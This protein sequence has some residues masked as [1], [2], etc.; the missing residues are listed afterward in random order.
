MTNCEPIIHSNVTSAEINNFVYSLLV[1]YL[2]QTQFVIRDRAKILYIEFLRGFVQKFVG[3]KRTKITF[4]YDTTE[5]VW[6]NYS[7]LR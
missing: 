7:L 2:L 5:L 6:L 3:P 1:P 4:F